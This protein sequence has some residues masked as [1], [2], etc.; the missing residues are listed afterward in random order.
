MFLSFY[1]QFVFSANCMTWLWFFFFSQLY[2]IFKLFLRTL[3]KLLSFFIRHPSFRNRS[4]A[5]FTSF[6]GKF[7]SFPFPFL[8]FVVRMILV[9]SQHMKTALLVS[10]L[11]L[12][13]FLRC[14][15]WCLEILASRMIVK[16][17]SGSWQIRRT[18]VL[19]FCAVETKMEAYALIFLEYFQL[20]KL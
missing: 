5:Y 1:L 12:Q 15:G 3:T 11:L 2:C 7:I 19:A 16:I 18:N 9:T 8:I 17:H 13:E 6:D 14:L 4:I 10:S 20:G